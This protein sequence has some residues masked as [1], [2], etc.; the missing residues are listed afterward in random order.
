MLKDQAV[1]MDVAGT[2]LK[3]Y[4]VAKDIGSGLL[5]ENIVT[6]ELIMENSGRALVVPQMDPIQ[7][8]FWRPE[9]RIGTIVEGREEAVMISCSSSPFSKELALRILKQSRA[10]VADL[11]EVNRAVMAKCPGNYQTSGIIVDENLLEVTHT[12]GTGGAPFPGL[13]DVLND[14]E[15]HGVDVY[16]A[17]GDSM[18]SLRY[19]LGF[20]IDLRR[21]FPVA[22]PRQK[23]EIVISLKEKYRKVI[24]VGDGLNDLYALKAADIGVLTVQQDSHPAKCLFDAADRIINDIVELPEILI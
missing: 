22:D 23:Q 16:L 15:R 13:S 24:M 20:G 7:L 6:W 11:Q 12:I 17:S 14:L 18:R 8:C 2:I 4:R 21:I 1:V 10:N 19:L 9:R 5:R 3:M